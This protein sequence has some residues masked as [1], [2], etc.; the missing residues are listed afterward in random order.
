MKKVARLSGYKLVSFAPKPSGRVGH[1]RE[2]AVHHLVL[3]TSLSAQIRCERSRILLDDGLGVVEASNDSEAR[4]LAEELQPD[5]VLIQV[6]V[7]IAD[8]GV[9]RRFQTAPLTRQIPVLFTSSSDRARRRKAARLANSWL[10]EPVTPRD[11]VSA[12]RALLPISNQSPSVCRRQIWQRFWQQALRARLNTAELTAEVLRLR[13]HI[14]QIRSRAGG[15]GQYYSSNA[16]KKAG[17]A[18]DWEA[19]L[20]AYAKDDRVIHDLL[21]PLGTIDS[22][23]AWLDGEYGSLLDTNGREYLKLLLMSVERMTAV[24]H[25]LRN[26]G[27]LEKPEI[28]KAI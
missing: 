8:S 27:V 19:R 16:Q 6:S 25:G 13:E 22:L 7:G 23:S 17:S 28:P 10:L 24:V 4:Q 11:L 9:W 2:R 5:A 21:S 20:R 14:T 3:N 18:G 12:V 26:E 1:A 15:S